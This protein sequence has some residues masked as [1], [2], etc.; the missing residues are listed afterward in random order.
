MSGTKKKAIHLRETSEVQ[1]STGSVV[2]DADER[3]KKKSCSP[4]EVKEKEATE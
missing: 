3:D 4:N 2:G 1:L